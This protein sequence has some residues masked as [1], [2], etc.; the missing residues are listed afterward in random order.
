LLPFSDADTH[1]RSFPV[2]NVSLIGI[3]ALVFLYELYIS[4]FGVIGGGDSE[5][6]SIFFF[7]WGFIPVELTRGAALTGVIETPTPTWTTIFSSLFMHGGLMHFAGNMMFLW[8][9]GDNIEDRMGHAKYLVFYLA[10]G[11][12]ATLSHWLIDPGSG[13]PL[14]GASGAIAGVLGAYLFTYPHNRVKVLV[15]FFLITVIQL[16]AM[17]V[18]GIWFGWNLIQWAFSIGISDRVSVAFSAHIGGFVFG[19][20]LIILYRLA[21][22]QPI[23][24]PRYSLAP[25]SSQFWR[26]RPLD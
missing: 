8:V 2:V 13:G 19:A 9:F 1:H 14:V 15:I 21:T 24:P 23:W 3:S 18:L 5:A 11:V 16:R 17:W 10:A 22:K 20:G 25:P 26:G 6:L 4:R 12:V 7:T